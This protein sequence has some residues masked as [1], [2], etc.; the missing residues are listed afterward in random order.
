MPRIAGHYRFAP[1]LDAAGNRIRRDGSTTDGWLII[2]CEPDLG[3]YLRQL[4]MMENRASPW[5]SDPLWGTHVSVVRG[6]A[7]PD[8]RAWNDRE[9]QLVEFEYLLPP[10]AVGEYAFFPVIC[11]DAL[12]YRERLGLPREPQWGLHL[13]FGNSK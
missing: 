10:Q 12:D 7:L 3:R 9:G 1:P 2:Q 11:E 13:T 6:E 8:P 4:R 5:L